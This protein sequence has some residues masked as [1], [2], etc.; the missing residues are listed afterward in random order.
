[1]TEENKREKLWE[2]RYIQNIYKEKPG[3][4]LD[5]FYQDKEKRGYNWSILRQ[6]KTDIKTDVWDA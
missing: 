6:K 5:F 1:M 2:E 3:T 4:I